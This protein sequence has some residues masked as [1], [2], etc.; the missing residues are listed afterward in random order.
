MGLLLWLV[1]DPKFWE[2]LCDS[3]CGYGLDFGE[4][5]GVGL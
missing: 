5:W 3:G 1:P 4:F 2:S